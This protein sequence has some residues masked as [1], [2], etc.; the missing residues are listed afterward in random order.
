MVFPDSGRTSS[1]T[2]FE[3]LKNPMVGI[4][5]QPGTSVLNQT[6]PKTVNGTFRHPKNPL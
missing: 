5:T 3:M 6:T 2:G 1:G 4:A